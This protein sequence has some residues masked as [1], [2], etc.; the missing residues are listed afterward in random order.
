MA[1]TI[2]DGRSRLEGKNQVTQGNVL[3][4]VFSSHAGASV[5][6]FVPTHGRRGAIFQ[7]PAEPLLGTLPDVMYW[8]RHQS[9]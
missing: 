5:E 3:D 4:P 7:G 1:L 6:I 8:V 2:D 9:T